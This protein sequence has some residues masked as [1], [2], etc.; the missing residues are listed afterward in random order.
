MIALYASAIFI[1]SSIPGESMPKA[2]SVYS[3]ALHIAEYLVLGFIVF[4]YLSRRGGTLFLAVLFSAMY[5][6]SDEIHQL[7]VPGRFFSVAD[8]ASDCVGSA[9][10]TL[11]SRRLGRAVP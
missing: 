4:P 6:V 11:T 10:G 9:V 8:I 3:T 7:F 2:V 1:G 5:G